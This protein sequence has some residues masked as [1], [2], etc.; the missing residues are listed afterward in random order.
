VIST[1]WEV[2]DEIAAHIA[3]HFYDQLTPAQEWA[4]GAVATAL[5]SAIRDVRDAYPLLPTAWAAHVHIGP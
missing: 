3:S 2:D 1:L 4:P 5:H